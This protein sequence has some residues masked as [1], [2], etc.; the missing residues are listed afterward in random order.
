MDYTDK[1]LLELLKFVAPG[2]EIRKGI[3]N[4]LD[5]GTGGLIVLGA[6]EEVLKLCDGGFHINT[7]YN[8]QRIYEL[9]KMDGAIVLTNDT[10]NIVYANVQLQPDPRIET[11]ESGTRHRTAERVAKQTGE[12][13]ISISQKRKII[14]IYKDE[15]KYTLRNISE[16]ITEA[17]QAIKTLERFGDV[18]DKSLKNL[19][20]MEFEDLVTLFELTTILQKFILMMKVAEEVEKYIV[21]LGVEGRLIE[22]QYEE[23][24]VDIKK[25]IEALIKDYYPDLAKLDLNL[26]LKKFRALAEEENAEIEEIAFILGYKKRYETLDQKVVPRGHRLLGKIKRLNLKDIANLSKSFDGL[27]AIIDASEDELSEVDGISKI[28]ARSIKN[29]IKR[30]MITIEFEKN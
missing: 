6:P 13:V 8:P 18:V 14:T 20:I 10:Q 24:M 15:M 26:V 4:I 25:E 27:P 17:N 23:I 28:K 3:D 16:I 7:P 22:T 9:A 19:T 1:K 2:T 11:K 29:E 21:E 30:L 12:S 5:A